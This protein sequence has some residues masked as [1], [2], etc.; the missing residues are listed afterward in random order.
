MCMREELSR[1]GSPTR[2]SDP[3]SHHLQPQPV[4]CDDVGAGLIMSPT[5]NRNFVRRVPDK[6]ERTGALRCVRSRVGKRERSEG[7]S[8][9]S[10]TRERG[11]CYFGG[12]EAEARLHAVTHRSSRGG[13]FRSRGSSPTPT[14]I[15]AFSSGLGAPGRL[16]NA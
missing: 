6:S 16:R 8:L 9:E 10:R 4:S 2:R 14:A 12:H 3:A 1:S 11:T 13:S 5:R 7:R 15:G